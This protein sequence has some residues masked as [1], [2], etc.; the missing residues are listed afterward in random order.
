MSEA[1]AKLVTGKAMLSYP[2]LD[3]PQAA[4]EG[5]KA[6]YSCALVF[7]P[8]ADLSAL[9]AAVVTAA[10]TKFGVTFKTPTGNIPTEEALA[11]GFIK[12]PFRRDAELKGYASGSV[13]I[14][15]RSDQKPG[16]VYL[17]AGPDG[18]KPAVVPDDKIREDLYA[19]CT[20]RASLTAFGYDTSGNKGVGF[21]LNNLQKL[22]DGER[23]DGRVKAE[24][25][26]DADLTQAPADL[27]SI[28]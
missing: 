19:G 8:G 10:K 27:S 18:V 11:K 22:S 7:T 5:Q 6:K 16:C 3:V 15:V 28:S 9:N 2:H 23:L 1:S 4:Q 21:A 12:S 26:F 14:N 24:N 20:V 17:H 13:F 25:E